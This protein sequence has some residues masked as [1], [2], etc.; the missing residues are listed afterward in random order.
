MLKLPTR[1]PNRFFN[2][3]VFLSLCMCRMQIAIEIVS[4]EGN[5][6]VEEE[7]RLIL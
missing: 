2:V 4:K 7:L 3:F 1:L 5:G 6:G